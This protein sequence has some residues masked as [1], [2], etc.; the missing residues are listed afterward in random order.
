[1][2][3]RT[4]TDDEFNARMVRLA[5]ERKAEAELNLEDKIER[6]RILMEF[7]RRDRER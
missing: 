4:E 7:E 1:M 5:R 2:S 6:A 3:E